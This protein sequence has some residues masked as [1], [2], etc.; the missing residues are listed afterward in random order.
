MTSSTIDVQNII[1]QWFLQAWQNVNLIN[2]IRTI[3]LI[4]EMTFSLSCTDV[5]LAMKAWNKCVFDVIVYSPKKTRVQE[6]TFSPTQHETHIKSRLASSIRFVPSRGE[7]ERERERNEAIWHH[8]T[9]G[10]QTDEESF[11]KI[12]KNYSIWQFI[13][14]CLLYN[15][16][17]GP[18]KPTL[19]KRF[20]AAIAGLA[21]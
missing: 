18:E 21:C 2:N 10:N 12:S 3:R 4:F 5:P 13:C 8:T 11:L 19:L 1:P 15:H 6:A 16:L 17:V 7:R 9:V 14:L 20:S